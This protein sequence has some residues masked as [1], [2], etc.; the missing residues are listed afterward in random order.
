M[1]PGEVG[2]VSPILYPLELL[3]LPE[4]TPG[5]VTGATSIVGAML[6]VTTLQD[7]EA[8]GT[9]ECSPDHSHVNHAGMNNIQ[10]FE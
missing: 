8:G 1:L 9:S 2:S 3:L 10:T 5:V 4:G 7:K 6:G